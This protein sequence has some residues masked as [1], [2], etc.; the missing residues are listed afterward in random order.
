LT[1]DEVALRRQRYG[2]S[3]ITAKH[4]NEILKFLHYFWPPI[5]WM[6]ETA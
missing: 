6:I 5:T 2:L 1:S 4:E 3:E